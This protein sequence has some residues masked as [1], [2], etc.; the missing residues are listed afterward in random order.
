MSDVQN[1]KSPDGLRAFNSHSATN[2]VAAAKKAT[3]EDTADKVAAKAAGEKQ[4]EAAMKP[5]EAAAA[6]KARIEAVKKANKRPQPQ[7]RQTKPPQPPRRQPKTRGRYEA[8]RSRHSRKEA[9]ARSYAVFVL[10]FLR[11][12]ISKIATKILSQRNK[13]KGLKNSICERN[14]SEEHWKA[15]YSK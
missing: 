15:R 3:E 1:F 2:T 5:T 8:N 11:P 13:T 14:K 7:R 4:T 6:A 12:L 9:K 10:N